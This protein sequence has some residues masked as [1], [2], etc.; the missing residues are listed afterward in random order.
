ML[1]RSLL[2]ILCLGSLSTL[3][4]AADPAEEIVVIG[5]TPSHGSGL[6]E[7]K[8]PYN[9]QSASVN[10]LDRSQSLDVTDFLNRNFLSIS[11]ND[12]QNNPLQPDVQYRGFTASPLLGLAQGL[13]IHQNGIRINEPLGDTVN[14][15]LI[16]E[17]AIHSINLISGA[18]PLF[19]LNTLGG[20]LNIEMKNGFNSQ[21]HQARIYGGSF[22]RIVTTL[23][24]GGNRSGFAY[25]GNLHYFR[26]DGWR[27]LS[28]SSNLDF[29]ASLGWHGQV[30]ELNLNFQHGRS[31]LN[32]NGPLPQELLALDRTTVFTAPDIT[33]NNL[34]MLSSDFSHS[35]T[36]YINL[37]GNVFYRHN[38]THSYNG[39]T[40]EFTRCALTNGD[41]LVRGLAND[42]L[43]ELG[44]D[45]Q[46]VCAG[47]VLNAA[48][49]AGLETI[50]N[51]LL[52]PGVTD[53]NIID[54][55]P[56]LSGTGTLAD[57]AVNNISDL[58]QKSFGT[59]V[60]IELNNDLLG[61]VN[62]MIA[63]FAWYK[64]ES[65]FRSRLELS[66]LDPVSRST[67]GLGTGTFVE[68]A[69]T[70]VATTTET[71]SF[72]ITDT[73]DLSEK[74]V[75]TLS[76]RFNN[77]RI[78]LADR[79]S[80]R[81]ELNGQHRF[82]RFNPAVGIT[83]QA[84]KD[85]NLYA[86]YS[87]SS[88]APTPIELTCNDSIYDLAVAN[89]VAAG[90][91]PDDVEYECRLPN[92][93]LSDPPLQQVIAS[94]IEFGLRGNYTNMS[95]HLG[96][97]HTTNKNDIIFQTTGRATGL[98]ANVKETARAGFESSIA[99]I[100]HQL[101]WFI[102][103]SYIEAT[104]EDNFDVLSP[105][106]PFA[107]GDGLIRVNK[108]DRIP[109]VPEHQFKLGADYIISDPFSVGLEFIFNSDQYL[110]GDESN[111]L[112]PVA[113]YSLLNLRGRYV[114]NKT[115]EIFTR[116]NNVLDK[117]Y[118]TFGLLGENPAELGIASFAQFS[119]SRFLGP[120]APRSVFAGIKITL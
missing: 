116:I 83:Y 113:G 94:N 57:A 102:N 89:A 120:G 55:T 7:T 12:A 93:F 110:R 53:F 88:R 18:N 77:T 90:Q 114:L 65:G 97:F 36:E 75:A 5:V 3:A 92:A 107:D 39:D 103:Y 9:V 81:P 69:A 16:P 2:I 15:D 54:L 44:L 112:A 111:Q 26:E 86:G 56:A 21:G 13:A 35:L 101:D 79:S 78:T 38:N 59:D 32:G 47:N 99:G 31:T 118:A 60:Q 19:G 117:D 45:K 14:W 71:F 37:S 82:N 66:G 68:T 33:R 48:D 8:I 22:N 4:L 63:G 42:Q 67:H 20:A 46:A 105:N 29:Y 115:F 6:P 10:D 73:I 98:F 61:R 43:D 106:H 49:P 64:G 74:L 11:I 25:Y 28:E 23:E 50:L 85:L 24:S 58:T 52:A 62:Q 34:N 91:N 17:S 84:A 41:F 100:W 76:G 27:D 95:Y 87:E 1:F 30:S 119:N 80:Q 108:G 40:T 109:G 70:S 96:F 104:F 72:Y 51:T